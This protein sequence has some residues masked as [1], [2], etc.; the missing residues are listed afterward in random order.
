[1][2]CR[3]L[4]TTHRDHGALARVEVTVRAPMHKVWTLFKGADELVSA[5]INQ[6]P[7]TRKLYIK[8]RE[9]TSR[10]TTPQD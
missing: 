7:E 5:L 6:A 9:F 1:V 4:L 8:L 2:L 3:Q 10:F